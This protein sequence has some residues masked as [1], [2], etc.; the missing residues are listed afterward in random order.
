MIIPRKKSRHLSTHQD[1]GSS[2]IIPNLK[3]P[4]AILVLKLMQA[5]EFNEQSEAGRQYQQ[6]NK[7][8]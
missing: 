7:S 3:H 4:Y 8:C 6:I 1:N 5:R 2:L